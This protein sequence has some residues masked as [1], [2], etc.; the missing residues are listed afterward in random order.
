M[1][2][3]WKFATMALV[4][5]MTLFTTACSDDTPNENGGD[6]NGNEDS[7]YTLVMKVQAQNNDQ[8]LVRKDIDMFLERLRHAT[9]KSKQA[10]QTSDEDFRKLFA[11]I[12]QEKVHDPP[13]GTT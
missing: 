3:N 11:S 6:G 13:P 7:A 10:A 2:K 1:K 5:S 9:P 4:A 8:R 12:T